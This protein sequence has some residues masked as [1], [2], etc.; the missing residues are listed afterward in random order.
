MNG[1]ATE[2]LRI[3]TQ[4]ST[5]PPLKDEVKNIFV[6]K[7]IA[8]N[9]QSFRQ[10]GV[11]GRAKFLEILVVKGVVP[12]GRL[13]ICASTCVRW[14]KRLTFIFNNTNSGDFNYNFKKHCVTVLEVKAASERQEFL[15]AK[16]GTA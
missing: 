2:E 6:C 14:K 7:E 8:E 5:A 11:K 15:L 16:F 9:N 1:V 13:F 10:C 4:S 12:S 3:L